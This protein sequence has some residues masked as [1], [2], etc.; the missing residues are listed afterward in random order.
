[1]KELIVNRS[2]LQLFRDSS[3]TFRWYPNAMEFRNSDLD[4]GWIKDGTRLW[5]LNGISIEPYCGFYS[6][7]YHS[8]G[9]RAMSGLCTMGSFSYTFS[10]LPEDVKVG[11]YCSIAKGLQ[12][13]DGYHPA[14][15]ITTSVV[16][17]KNHLLSDMYYQDANMIHHIKDPIYHDPSNYPQIGDDVWIGMDVMMK[18]GVKIGDG[19]I[20]AAGS[21]ITK[22]VEP[23]TIV[24]GNP[25][26]PIKK[27]F[28]DSTIELLIKSRI[29]SYNLVD[30]VARGLIDYSNPKESA[31]KVLYLSEKGTISGY[32]PKVIQLPNLE[33]YAVA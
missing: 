2:L 12:F 26:K 18:M 16:S 25:A 14:D 32:K 4:S 1:M 7:V 5:F 33:S 19:A 29:F 23:Y 8:A 31:E 9:V 28:D 6:G 22:D 13:L 24:G 10:P 20:V 21:I 17:F 11:R 3:I 15:R 30:L 27:R